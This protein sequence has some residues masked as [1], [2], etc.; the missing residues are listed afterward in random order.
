MASEKI[1][2]ITVTDKPDHPGC[3][4]L[5]ESAEYWGWDLYIQHQPEGWERF[6]Y[7]AEQQGLVKAIDA[8]NL[9]HWVMYLDAWDT[10][11]VGPPQELRLRE[12][13]VTFCGDQH[14]FPSENFSKVFPKVGFKEFPFLNCGVMWGWGPTMLELCYKYLAIPT[15]ICNQDFFN[16]QYIYNLS[17]SNFTMNID[18]QAESA[19]NL[20]GMAPKYADLG[21]IRRRVVYR[22]T[23]TRPVVLHAAGS[24]TFHDLPPMPT[25]AVNG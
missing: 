7:K 4:R 15:Q 1:V 24:S 16:T 20:W 19:L 21:R 8:L 10:M 17:M 3:V 13:E 11:F 12:Q 6:T 9:P 22:P 25:V 23:D 5:K 18:H 2:A 14:C